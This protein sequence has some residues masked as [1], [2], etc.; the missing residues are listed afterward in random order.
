MGN[1]DTSEHEV[2][3]LANTASSTVATTALTA[4]SLTITLHSG[5]GALFPSNAPFLVRIGNALQASEIV[6]VTAISGDTLSIVR[7]RNAKAWPLTTPVALVLPEGGGD[8]WGLAGIATSV[9]A[10]TAIT[11]GTGGPLLL[12]GNAA[13][14]LATSGTIATAG[15][16]ISRISLA[17]NATAVVLQAGTVDGQVV[18]VENDSSSHTATFDVAGTSHVADGTS[19]V[20]AALTCLAYVWNNTTTLWYK[21]A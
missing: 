16:S 5:D 20:I 13:Q 7:G 4:A 6:R 3:S 17:A 18:I 15:L 19:D 9:T 2:A 10:S 12:H 1:S 8:L 21:I 14:A 11:A